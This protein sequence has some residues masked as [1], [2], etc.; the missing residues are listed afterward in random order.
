MD[1]YKAFK[2]T[3]VANV[4]TLD[5]GIQSSEAELKTV[6]SIILVVEAHI[7]NK[8]QVWLDQ[9]K[10]GEVYDYAIVTLEASGTDMYKTVANRVLELEINVELSLGQTL[11]CGISCGG[12]D[13]D[14][15]GS[16]RYEIRGR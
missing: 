2:I 10:I 13:T 7:G 8:V 4:E 5:T 14:V 15:Y 1:L 16:Y 9:E 6:K 12:T 3:G 11:Q